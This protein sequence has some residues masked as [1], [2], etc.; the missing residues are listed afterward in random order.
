[1]LLFAKTRNRY[2]IILLTLF[3]ILVMG[4]V[5]ACQ[6]GSDQPA[7]EPAPVEQSATESESEP[8]EET[9]AEEAVSA[10]TA[11]DEGEP[12]Q[13]AQADAETERETEAAPA[14]ELQTFSVVPD[15]SEARFYINEVL[16]GQPKT[17]VGVTSDVTG[18]IRLDPNNPSASEIGEITINARDL[19]TDADRRN[20]AIRRFILQTDQDQNQY[21]TF[22]PT[23]IDGMP[24]AVTVG[25]PF[26]FQVTG[27]LQIRDVVATETFNVTVTPVSETEITGTASATVLRGDY[28]LTIP[29]VPSVTGVEEEV[30]LEFEFTAVAQ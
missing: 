23:A 21:I 11:E 5:A 19:T 12:A 25:D 30:G 4:A 26:E 28:G 15:G 13:D 3:L 20:G 17:V 18:E 10:E 16:F 1:M 2:P 8:A 27:D 9:A 6:S 24:D 22:M 14:G 7:E 29:E